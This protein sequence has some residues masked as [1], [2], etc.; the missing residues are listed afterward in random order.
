MFSD[1]HI[2]VVE[3]KENIV[4]DNDG[5]GIADGA[6]GG[7]SQRLSGEIAQAFGEEVGACVLL[8]GGREGADG[9]ARQV[10]GV[11]FDADGKR[12]VGVGD[13]LTSAEC[14]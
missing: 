6:G 3:L 11:A 4:V 14:M 13:H 1:R 8:I 9:A 7:V 2:V 12:R 10:D 5:P